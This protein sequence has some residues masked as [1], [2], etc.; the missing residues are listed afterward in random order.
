MGGVPDPGLQC[1]MHGNSGKAHCRIHRLVFAGLNPP[2]FESELSTMSGGR[3]RACI[4]PN[5]PGA[6]RL[7]LSDE[8]L[9]LNEDDPRCI[10]NGFYVGVCREHADV[11]FRKAI[12]GPASVKARSAIRPGRMNSRAQGWG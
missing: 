3:C 11:V 2:N 8:D 1:V 4:W 6:P 9:A 10:Q 7:A 12:E 5:R